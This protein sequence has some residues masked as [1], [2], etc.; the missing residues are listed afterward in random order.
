MNLYIQ[1][2]GNFIKSRKKKY[3]EENL[4]LIAQ[5]ENRIW[6]SM[7]NVVFVSIVVEV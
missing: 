3:D 1:L 2:N 7:K 5:G 6:K 4:N